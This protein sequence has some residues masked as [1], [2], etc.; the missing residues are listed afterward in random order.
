MRLKLL[1]PAC[2]T[3]P[4]AC[5]LLK[6]G[7]KAPDPIQTPFIVNG[8][9]GIP[10]RLMLLE[11]AS[12]VFISSKVHFIVLRYNYVRKTG[13]TELIYH[14]KK[15]CRKIKR[16]RY[17]IPNRLQNVLSL[18]VVALLLHLMRTAGNALTV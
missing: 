7:G 10:I 1:E 9:R 4:S 12:L 8:N 16:L 18:T 3:K 6:Q 5:I 2:L 14:Q 15:R 17:L 11:P 13:L